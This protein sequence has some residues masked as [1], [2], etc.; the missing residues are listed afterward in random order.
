MKTF[1]LFV[2]DEESL[3]VIKEKL[4]AAYKGV[5]TA[6]LIGVLAVIQKIGLK[7][8]KEQLS[9]RGIKGP[10]KAFLN[11]VNFGGEYVVN[12]AIAEFLVLLEEL[13]E[14]EDI[15]LSYVNPRKPLYKV[16]RNIHFVRLEEEVCA[17]MF[18]AEGTPRCFK[19]ITD[20]EAYVFSRNYI[21]TNSKEV[22]RP[23]TG[24]RHGA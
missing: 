9:V 23:Y 21:T 19:S 18:S 10:E 20:L 6:T 11:I 4:F 5:S 13:N 8:V 2:D 22:I 7:M 16:L 14:E 12:P 1:L 24:N 15:I 17:G 3:K